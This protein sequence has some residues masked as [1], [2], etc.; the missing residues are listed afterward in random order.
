MFHDS[1]SPGL[2]ITYLNIS[3]CK[4]LRCSLDTMHAIINLTVRYVHTDV[5]KRS[6]SSELLQHITESSV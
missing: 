2:Q 1:L 3:Q 4:L 5:S 6:R